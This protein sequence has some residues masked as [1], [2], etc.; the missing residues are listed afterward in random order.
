MRS[1]NVE[2]RASMLDRYLA[3][4]SAF[5]STEDLKEAGRLALV[6]GALYQVRTYSQLLPTVMPDDLGR[7]RD[8][9]IGWLKR[10]LLRLNQGL[11][12]P[13]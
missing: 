10:A 1:D 13:Y 11:D 7:L 2:T 5:L 4:W 3:H 6:V 9:D 12:G 8:G